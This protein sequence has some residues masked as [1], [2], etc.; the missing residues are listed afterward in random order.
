MVKPNNQVSNYIYEQQQLLN[1]WIDVSYKV[2][3]H[4]D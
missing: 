3:N 2:I 4:N 1:N